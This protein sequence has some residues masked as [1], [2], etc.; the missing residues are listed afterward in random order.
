M[1]TF[2]SNR[3]QG[4]LRFVLVMRMVGVTILVLDRAIYSVNVQFATLFLGNV[5]GI[6][7]SVML[8]AKY[9]RRAFGPSTA[10]TPFAVLV[11]DDV[12]ALIFHR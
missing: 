10:N 9:L 4:P 3:I 11:R 7:D 2:L 5:F 8:G 12:L 1:N 6:C